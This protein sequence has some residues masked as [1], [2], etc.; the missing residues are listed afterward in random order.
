MVGR[1]VV[2]G[3]G[4]GGGRGVISVQRSRHIFISLSTCATYLPFGVEKE[5]N[6]SFNGLGG[7]QIKP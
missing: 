3:G 1:V 2:G 4:G 7:V 6:F 5:I